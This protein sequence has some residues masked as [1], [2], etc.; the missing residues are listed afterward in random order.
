[1]LAVFCGLPTRPLV[2]PA[3]PEAAV[4]NPLRSSPLAP[5]PPL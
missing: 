3:P 1:M 5:F 4:G 2:C